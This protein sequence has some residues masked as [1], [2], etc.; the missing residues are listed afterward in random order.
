MAHMAVDDPDGG[1]GG[2]VTCEL[3]PEPLGSSAAFRI[4]QRVREYFV[5][6]LSLA[7]QGSLLVSMAIFQLNLG[8]ST[9]LC[10]Y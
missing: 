1:E 5:T 6:A 4:Q 10:I 2:V 3:R 8:G 7:L 9:L